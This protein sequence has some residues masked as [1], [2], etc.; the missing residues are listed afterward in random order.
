MISKMCLSIGEKRLYISGT[1]QDGIKIF[2]LES[3][4]II[5]NKNYLTN[6]KDDTFTD[7]FVSDFKGKLALSTRNK[8]MILKEERFAVLKE[9][10]PED[11]IGMFQ[12]NCS[13]LFYSPQR[14]LVVWWSGKGTISLVNLNTMKVVKTFKNLF[15]SGNELLVNSSLC[16]NGEK[17]IALTTGNEFKNIYV[18]D[19]VDDVAPQQF[20]FT[21]KG[22]NHF[23]LLISERNSK[24][25]FNFC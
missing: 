5:A 14:D 15:A 11:T 7:G 9:F 4:E 25:S 12:P 23:F 22:C 19:L 13:R 2:D 8:L 10:E 6:W 24:L 1:C 20:K 3:K 21:S 17:M 18:I 16:Q